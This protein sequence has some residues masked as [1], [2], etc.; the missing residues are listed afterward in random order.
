MYFI[1]YINGKTDKTDTLKKNKC[2]FIKIFVTVTI[3]IL[4]SNEKLFY[5]MSESLNG[6]I[7]LL[8]YE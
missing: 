1:L 7:K 5:K 4:I 2:K 6:L 8:R 3:I